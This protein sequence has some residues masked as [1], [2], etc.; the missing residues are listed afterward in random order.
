MYLLFIVES[1]DTSNRTSQNTHIT[2]FVGE[3]S[4]SNTRKSEFVK[5]TYSDCKFPN[6]TL[7]RINSS[8]DVTITGNNNF[9]NLQSRTLI[10]QPI[11]NQLGSN[12]NEFDPWDRVPILS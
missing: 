6:L 7:N 1:V 3:A 12:N 5:S 4:D 11:P 8:K 9:E 10:S 2:F